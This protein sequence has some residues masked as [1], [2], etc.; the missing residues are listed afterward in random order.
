MSPLS[1]ETGA[2]AATNPFVEVFVKR[3]QRNQPKITHPSLKVSAKFDYAGSH[4]DAS[5]ASSDLAN[6]I[7]IEIIQ[8]DVR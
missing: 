1:P 3:L 8:E 5:I 4:R 7:F 6:T 2:H